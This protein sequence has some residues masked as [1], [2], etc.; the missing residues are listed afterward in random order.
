MLLKI[1]LSTKYG[2]KK[3]LSR[4][5]VDEKGLYVKRKYVAKN[6]VSK[7]YVVEEEL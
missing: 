6:S 7:K 2:A 1:H 3:G 4:K 5:Y